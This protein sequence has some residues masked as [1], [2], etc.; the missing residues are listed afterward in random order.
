MEGLINYFCYF[1][2]GTNAEL[3]V[4]CVLTG[5]SLLL[6]GDAFRKYVKM[7]GSHNQHVVL[8]YWLL[9][10]WWLSTFFLTQPTCLTTPSA[11]FYMG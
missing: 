4:D 6:V 5:L 2:I 9:F 8:V 3:I 7:R 11:T 1:D 10:A